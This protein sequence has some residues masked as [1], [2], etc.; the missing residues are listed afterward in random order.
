MLGSKY[1]NYQ[2]HYLIKKILARLLSWEASEFWKSHLL[3]VSLY[4]LFMEYA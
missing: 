2:P 4:L 1:D 3:Y